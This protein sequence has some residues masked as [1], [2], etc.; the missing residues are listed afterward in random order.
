MVIVVL[1]ATAIMAIPKFIDLQN[2][3][4]RA[5]AKAFM[6]AFKSGVDILHAKWV[7]DNKPAIVI[8]Q[9]IPFTVNAEGWATG[10][11]ADNAG[12][13]EMW[14]TLLIAPPAITDYAGGAPVP[15]WAAWSSGSLCIY[16]NQYGK[17]FNGL[18]TPYFVYFT[19]TFSPTFTAGSVFGLNM[20]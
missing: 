7:V 20:P 17:S 18:E 19:V 16:F 3:S 10:S 2:A 15:S 1:G 6:G 9:G 4:E 8:N 12:C 11:T 13:R 14:N 5:S